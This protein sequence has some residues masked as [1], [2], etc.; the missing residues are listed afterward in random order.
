[1]S[2]EI[3]SR[4]IFSTIQIHGQDIFN[5]P[6]KA[7]EFKRA[8][9]LETEQLATTIHHYTSINSFYHIISNQSFFATNS[10]YLNDKEEHNYRL[11]IF[12]NALNKLSEKP[13]H[14]H[15]EVDI[16][17]QT[18]KW[19]GEVKLPHFYAVCFSAE[20]NNI[21]LWQNY[22]DN[23]NG[24]SMGFDIDTLPDCF[25]IPLN[26]QWINYGTQ[27]PENDLSDY[28]TILLK[29][30]AQLPKTVNFRNNDEYLFY[31]QRLLQMLL[32][33]N[34]TG[35]TKHHSFSYEREFRLFLED[36]CFK[37]P[38]HVEF[39]PKNNYIAPFVR[40]N[41][42]TP[43]TRRPEFELL[44]P[45]T[46]KLLKNHKIPKRLPLKEVMLGPC[47]DKHFVEPGL[48]AFLKSKGY[49]D[50]V[51]SQSDIPYRNT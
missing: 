51:I 35:I 13:T 16:I 11:K 42:R 5:D 29:E 21:S 37:E 10:L 20:Q 49:D 2:V 28:L 15:L 47:V 18:K 39:M 32:G 4:L 33:C 43:Y 34:F 23:G 7:E 40:L 6:L 1:M 8:L 41:L 3:A 36:D 38:L 25:H 12:E 44:P 46:H 31:I 50:V 30:Y 27:F 45:Q 24:I 14:E 9:H 48:R 22:G 17:Q 19:L 26:S